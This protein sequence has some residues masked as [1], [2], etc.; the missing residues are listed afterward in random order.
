MKRSVRNGLAVVGMAGG[1]WLLGH[2]VANAATDPAPPGPDTTVSQSVTPQDNSSS[3]GSK[4]VAAGTNDNSSSTGTG[5]TTGGDGGGNGASANTGATDSTATNNTAGTNTTTPTTPTTPTTATTNSTTTPTT[6]FEGDPSKPVTSVTIV[7]GDVTA[8]QQANGGDV[9]DSGNVD[10]TAAPVTQTA[11]ANN[12]VDQTSTG[13]D[14]DKSST[15]DS[16]NN[17]SSDQNVGSSTDQNSSSSNTGNGDGKNVAVSGNDNSTSVSTGNIS[18]GNG[19][20]NSVDINTGLIGNTFICPEHSTCTYNI[21]TGNVTVY[22][23][24]NGGS[25]T[26]SGNVTIGKKC[27]CHKAAAPP[28]AAPVVKT[29]AM[30]S[31]AALSGAQP[32]GVLATTG[33]DYSTPLTVGL[34]ALGAGTALTLAGRRRREVEAA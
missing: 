21:T 11:T 9:A 2:A 23:E 14:G 1:M 12:K 17:S 15:S 3:D 8:N 10:S 13:T 24:A 25:V 33:A 19:G 30:T 6:N 4:T 26:N 5:N 16:D 7:T 22:Q 29:A 20:S 34:L 18:G 31:A 32:S 27:G 28:T